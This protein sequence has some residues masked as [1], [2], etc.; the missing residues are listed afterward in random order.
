MKTVLIT[1]AAGGVGQAVARRFTAGGW[2]VIGTDLV[3]A[4]GVDFVADLTEV[5]ECRRV[6][7]EAAALNGGLDGVVLA[8]GVWTEGD[9]SMTSEAEY[10]RCFDVNV[11]ATYF[12]ISAAIAHLVKTAGWI[13]ALSSDAGV[14]G[15]S[16]AAV[17][18]ATKG[19]VTNLVRALSHELAPQGVRVNA[20][21]PGDIDTP[22]LAG[23]ARDFGGDDP[24]AY[25]DALLA[26][27]PQGERARFISPDEVA[28][29]IWFLG[30]PE[31][32][33]ITGANL[34]IDFG[35]SAGI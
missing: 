24:K 35:L 6:V 7:A 3:A 33:P 34:N 20:V 21:C 16:G 29:L 8:A 23:Q 4:D 5:S 1:G 18:S 30:Q 14:Q 13:T 11:K 17:Y 9:S 22:M 19:A 25:L 31:A 26:S 32:A 12:T 2:Q 28:A 10:D 27:Y 15:N